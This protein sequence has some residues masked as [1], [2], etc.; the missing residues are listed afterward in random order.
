MD[1]V[2]A[3]KGYSMQNS[4]ALLLRPMSQD[5]RLLK[6]A[7]EVF[8]GFHVSANLSGS[9]TAFVRESGKPTVVDPQ[10]YLFTLRPERLFDRKTNR[11]KGS[12][13]TM[14]GHYGPPFRDAVGARSL[15]PMD[16]ANA[17]AARTCVENVLSYQRAKFSGQMGLAFDA[18]FDKYNLWGREEASAAPPQVL[19]PPYFYIRGSSDP[20]L[21]TNLALA[22]HAL[23][24]RRKGEMIYPVLLFSTKILSDPAA[25]DAIAR[26]Y[27]AE[28]FDGILLWPN[29]FVE[30]KQPRD[31]LQG[32]VRM[33]SVF[34]DAGRR[35]TKLY[36]GYLSALLVSRGLRGFSCG[37][38]YGA[39]KNAFAV[40][41]G[42]GKPV[43]R[44]Y[45]PRLH[46]S[47]RFDEAEQIL[48]MNS[49]LR[50]RCPVCAHLYGAQMDRFTRMQEGGGSELHFLHA[51]Q[52]ELQ[53][54][55]RTGSAELS[56][57]LKATS[58]EF[59]RSASVRASFLRDWSSLLAA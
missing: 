51:R 43:P 34:A 18:T 22:R 17:A 30:E 31:Q 32:L 19:L 4:P 53:E 36:G 40:G 9:L 11:V 37:L 24:A 58:S 38:G 46:C 6:D 23:E 56:R 45:I 15:T 59:E 8:R 48:R 27:L 49:S 29:D 21:T 13:A 10:T 1:Q 5:R 47:V 3:R 20:W 41:G 35:V 16:F 26:A 55:G 28:A 52:A 33:L 12:I 7:K 57:E 25:I 44:F 2:S 42:G 39:S 54:I 14:A 50:C